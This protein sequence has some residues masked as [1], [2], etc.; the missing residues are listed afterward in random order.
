VEVDK[1]LVLNLPAHLTSYNLFVQIVAEERIPPWEIN[2]FAGRLMCKRK[3]LLKRK[4][5]RTHNCK[6]SLETLM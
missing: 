1:F 5:P 2:P 6:N 4:S 3:N